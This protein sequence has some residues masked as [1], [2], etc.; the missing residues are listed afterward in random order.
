ML[1]VSIY[2]LHGIRPSYFAVI[3]GKVY[4]KHANLCLFH[5]AAISLSILPSLSDRHDILVIFENLKLGRD[6]GS[7]LTR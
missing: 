3:T 4:A 1:G 6:D 5:M 2:R 7:E